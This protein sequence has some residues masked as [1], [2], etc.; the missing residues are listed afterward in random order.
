MRRTL[1]LLA[2]LALVLL[3]SLVLLLRNLPRSTGPSPDSQPSGGRQ[4]LV[5]AALFL[6]PY[7][8]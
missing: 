6:I 7:L 5:W 4:L 8:M 3:A 1:T 2:G